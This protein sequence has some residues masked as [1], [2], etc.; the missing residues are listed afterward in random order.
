MNLL[1]QNFFKKKFSNSIYLFFLGT[2]SAFSLPPYNYFIINFITF[3]LFFIFLFNKKK[4]TN[5]NKSFFKY[6]WC[7]G[8]GYFLSSLYWI[9]ISLTFDQ[10][11]KLLIPLAI[12]LV[13]AFLAIFYGL[14]TYLFSILY[15]KKVISSFLIFSILFGI[16]ELIRGYIL[17]GFPWNLIAFS[18]YENKNFIQIL[19]IIGTY[20]FNLICISLFT[21][22]ALFILR[23]SRKEIVVCFIFI[24]ISVSFLIFGT[25]KNN[26]FDSIK[27]VE[28]DYT[29]RVISSDISLNRFYSGEDELK[30]INELISLS[31]PDKKQTTIFLWPEGIIPDTYLGDMK[32]YKNLFFENFGSNH[33]IIMGINRLK[34]KNGKNLFFNSMAIFDRELNLINSYNKINL[35]P[36]GEFIPFENF[37]GFIGLRTITNDYQSFSSGSIR[38]SLNIKNDKFNLTLLPLICYEIIYSGKLFKNENFDYIINI[39]EDG[40]F[41]ESIGHKQHFAHSIFRSIE[42]GKYIIRSANNGISAIINPIGVIEQEVEYGAT[43]YI[44][45]TESK[46]MKP[47]LFSIHGNIIFIILILLYIFFIFSF[48][49]IENE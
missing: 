41:G 48:N 20:S 36:F 5:K 4:K 15:S 37:L 14:I 9:S 47:T 26:Q 21:S 32:I 28:N 7:F 39:S 25:I 17:T 38:K 46:S 12:I 35:V 16:I 42:S 45:F 33:L 40:W 43:G 10:S 6:G 49:R 11:F 24:L 8:F 2:I 44:D 18:F 22:P 3:T 31:K 1:I 27:S 13:P 19:S 30:I 23:N 34:N 29:I